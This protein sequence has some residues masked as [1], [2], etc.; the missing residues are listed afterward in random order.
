MMVRLLRML[1]LLALG[2]TL[3]SAQ[4]MPVTGLKGYWK[5]D[6][7]GDLGKA[8]VGNPLLMKHVSTAAGDVNKFV[9]ISGPTGGDGAVTVGLGSYFECTPD[10]AAYPDTSVNANRY[11][12]AMDMRIPAK[13]WHSFV[14]FRPDTSGG[15]FTYDGDFQGNPD[16]HI[17]IGASGYSFDTLALSEW[18]RVVL[19]ADLQKN[20]YRIYVD[21][22]LAHVGKTGPMVTDGRFSIQSID[23]QNKL[24]FI[25]DNDGDDGEMDVAFI[26]LY[27]QSMTSETIA[28]WGGYGH[29]VRNDG[30]VAQWDFD[31][32]LAPLKAT[33][34][35]DLGLS[36][37]DAD[38]AGP[39]T[40]NKARTISSGNHYIA[41]SSIPANG[42]PGAAKT[43]LYAMKIDFRANSVATPHP[44]YQADS[45]NASGAEAYI[46]TEG[47]IGNP[48][49]GYSNSGIR[50]G[51][52]HRLIINADLAK[53]VDYWLDG[54]PL[55]Q[56]GPQAID[57]RFAL[58][59]KGSLKSLLFFAD[60]ATYGGGSIDVSGISLW[61][62]TLDSVE[63]VTLGE[64]PIPPTDTAK[65]PAGYAVYGDGI[66]AHNQ[67]G[68][69]PI[70]SDYDFDSTKSFTIELWT[71]AIANWS[72]D[73]SIIGDKA[74]TSGGNPGFVISADAGR[75]HTW[76]FNLADQ[77]RNRIDINMNNDPQSSLNDNKWHHIAVTVDQT[78]K[79][80]MAYT[81]GFFVR[82]TDMSA[83][84]GSLRGKVDG[85]DSTWYPICLFEDGTQTY[86]PDNYV[87]GGYIDEVRIWKGVALDSLTLRAWMHKGLDNTHPNY[88]N[89]AGY[90]TFEEGSGTTSAD[91]SGHGNPV[92]LIHGVDW[93]TSFALTD[94]RP[95]EGT[96]PGA[97][98]LDN[99]YP[100]PFNPST[101]IRF[102][103]AAASTVVLKVYNVLGQEVATL[104]NGQLNGGQHQLV[105]NARL[106]GNSQAA[107]GVYFYRL[108]ATGSNGSRFIETKKLV[109]LK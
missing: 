75:N 28:A 34:G 8:E 35:L 71:R 4:V 1:P 70:T 96:V 16:M 101:T 55:M 21:G 87:Y 65:G 92:T 107:S 31:D 60:S 25:G 90:W 72:G 42:A 52:W 43:N 32:A 100:N 68:R 26:A 37:S 27:D 58:N 67:Y 63:I 33:T 7:A 57:G 76:K 102:T 39:T 94:V 29:S 51:A 19:T 95:I 40:E 44:L 106:N 85:S 91:L 46:S 24:I 54:F 98:A 99:A 5:F 59:P 11:T 105:W 41:T 50:V 80:A 97:Y 14:V 45:T 47:T 62:R 69:L 48:V 64:V 109:L 88:A 82:A 104:V 10:M 61:N 6:S 18:Y 3:A 73:P 103:L 15:T 81:D 83:L 9:A 17:G 93:R 12:I 56:G 2:A 84:V 108:D 38:V 36:G 22:Q 49:S 86:E 20:D 79:L 66:F 89:L 78:Q 74:W 13:A 77:Y 23:Q 30:P 53:S